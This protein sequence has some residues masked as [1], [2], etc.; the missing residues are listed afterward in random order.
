MTEGLS[1]RR[2]NDSK[3]KEKEFCLGKLEIDVSCDGKTKLIII[4]K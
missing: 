4:W 3:R 2:Y 1:K